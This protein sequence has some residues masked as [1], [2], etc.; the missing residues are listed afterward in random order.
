MIYFVKSIHLDCGKDCKNQPTD[1]KRNDPSPHPPPYLMSVL[2]V[3]HLEHCRC[4][5]DNP[6]PTKH[7]AACHDGFLRWQQ[8]FVFAAK[9]DPLVQTAQ[10]LIYPIRKHGMVVGQAI[11]VASETTQILL[12]RLCVEMDYSPFVCRVTKGR[13]IE[14]LWGKHKEKT[15]SISLSI[16][17]SIVTTLPAVQVY[18]FY[19]LCQGTMNSSVHIYIHTYIMH[20]Y[21]HTYTHTYVHTYIYIF[22]YIHTYTHIRTYINVYILFFSITVSNRIKQVPSWSCSK[23]VYKPGM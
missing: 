20:T 10:P 1:G 13:S 15:W 17:W 19:E 7:A 11:L 9:A 8:W 2:C 5:V 18:R 21:M 23:A 14:H 4:Q 6:F 3:R 12:L 22:I 16:C